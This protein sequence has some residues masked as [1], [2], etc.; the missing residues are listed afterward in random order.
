MKLLRIAHVPPAAVG[1]EDSVID[2]VHAMVRDRVGAVAVVAKPGNGALLGIFTERDLMLRVVQQ[3]RSPLETKVRDVMTT[4]VKTSP[5]DAAASEA[6]S[7][8]LSHHLRHLPIVGSEGQV[9]GIL[10]IRDL[11][12]N[13]VDDLTQALDSMEQYITNDSMGG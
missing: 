3:G 11:L 10:S 2:A 9:L 5:E 7:L 6:M 13:K 12:E 8:M 1:P 4:E